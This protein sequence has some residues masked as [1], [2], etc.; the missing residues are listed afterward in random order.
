MAFSPGFMVPPARVGKP[1]VFVSHGNQ[2]KILPLGNT[3]GKTV[4]Q[5]KQWGYEV[6]YREFA[7]NHTIPPD[8]GREAFRWLLK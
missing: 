4:P 7:G 3:R 5:L 6:I 2:D 8:V 1:R